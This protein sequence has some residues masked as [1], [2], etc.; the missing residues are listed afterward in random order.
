MITMNEFPPRLDEAEI[1]V[2]AEIIQKFKGGK[3]R[4]RALEELTL[5]AMRDAVYYLKAFSRGRNDDGELVS[6]AYAALYRASLRFQPD[7][8]TTFM[9]FAK[10]FLRGALFRE[11]RRASR[12]P[13]T[14][15]TID[16]YDDRMQSEEETGPWS[17][18]ADAAAV[19]PKSLQKETDF[20]QV[21]LKEIWE[22]FE[23]YLRRL[24]PL[25]QLVIR[26]RYMHGLKFS[27]IAEILHHRKQNYQQLHQRALQK[28]RLF[29]GVEK[30]TDE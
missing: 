2:R 19:V 16:H 30:K 28:L 20:D 18:E 3:K 23:P 24:S 22:R 12:G 15:E 5:S 17:E 29:I 11:W 27:E 4:D 13:K 6:L 7:H 10:A 1:K 21:H 25:E 14:S 8:G 9:R 26:Y